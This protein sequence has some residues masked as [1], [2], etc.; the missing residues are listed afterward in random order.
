M[1]SS[2]TLAAHHN[3]L[4]CILF[5]AATAWATVANSRTLI[6]FEEGDIIGVRI[7]CETSESVVKVL[8]SGPQGAEDVNDCFQFAMNIPCVFEAYVDTV[9]DNVGVKFRVIQ[10]I[11][12]ARIGYD[13]LYTVEKV[14]QRDS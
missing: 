1:K 12:L 5:F 8:Q 9:S 3:L 4:I 7:A 10:C 11:P 6:S 14:D 2:R 13:K